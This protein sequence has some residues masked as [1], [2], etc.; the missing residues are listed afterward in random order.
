[1]PVADPSS[2]WGAKRLQTRE[3]MLGAAIAEPRRSGMA[4]A[5]VGAIVPTPGLGH[6]T[7]FRFST[8]NTCS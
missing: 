1:M 8:R 6:G 5:D 3:R 2:V 7:F 4:V